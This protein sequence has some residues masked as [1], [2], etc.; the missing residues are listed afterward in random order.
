MQQSDKDRVVFSGSAACSDTS[1]DPADVLKIQL[2][3]FTKLL[4]DGDDGGRQIVCQ[5]DSIASCD[6]FSY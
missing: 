4:A 2:Q 1:D 6:I 3:E 5:S